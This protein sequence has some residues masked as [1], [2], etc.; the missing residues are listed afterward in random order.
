MANGPSRSAVEVMDQLFDIAV[1]KNASDIHLVV[2]K[3]P[4]LRIYGEMVPIEGA[5][6]LTRDTVQ[7][8]TFSLLSEAEKKTIIETKELDVAHQI[9]SGKRFRINL[10][11]EK[12][13][14]A[15][16]A[17]TI[18]SDIPTME[19][20]ELP[21]VIRDMTD[22]PHG[23]V[24]VTGPTGSGK[25]TTL[26]AMIDKINITEPVNIIT[27]EDPIEFLFEAKM[28]VIRQ[29]QLGQ[30][31]LSYGEG[32]KHI[33]RQDPDVVMVGEMRDMDT[34][35]TTL[36]IAETGHLAFATLHT[37][38]AA[39]TIDRIIDAFPP[40]QQSQVRS[41]LA[42]TLR[43]VVS[44]QLLPKIGGGRIAAREILVNT[45]AVANLIRENK[46]P[47]IKNVLQTSSADGMVTLTQ[48]LNR[49]IKEKLVDKAIA[50]Q[51][52]IGNEV[53]GADEEAPAKKKKA[54]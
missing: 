4:L 8:L 21:K 11:W 24:L 38:S 49:L 28:G 54:W 36:T 22:Y 16:A 12:T 29:R 41:Q 43:G 32:L 9:P 52:V 53:L 13:N 30:D 20:L 34:I 7:E 35:G 31:F 33:L 40:N 18:P 45:P 25:S 27:L 17:R 46:I 48:D 37:Y 15:M 2:G 5:K 3:P 10:H 50:Q 39:Q 14:L 6:A 47:Q 51:Y 1:A 23:L 44:Q 26:A 42:L 19:G